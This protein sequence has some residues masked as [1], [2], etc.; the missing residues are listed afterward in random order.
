MTR[1][2]RGIEK[3]RKADAVVGVCDAAGLPMP[4]AP[5]WVEQESHA[6]V[7][8]CAVPELG[9]LCESD[10]AR[11]RARLAEVFNHLEPAGR[12]ADAARIEAPDGVHLGALRLLLDRHAAGPPALVHVRGRTIG[13]ADRDERNAAQRVVDL[14]SLCFS[15][16][17]VRGVFWNG[18]RDGDDGAGSGLLRA[19]LSAKPVFRLLQKLIGVVWHTRA[20]GVT[21]ADG[22]FHVRGFYGNY[23]IGVPVGER[24]T[25]ALFSL[26]PDAEEGMFR[27]VVSGERPA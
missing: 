27:V 12:P 9:G 13:M 1:T 25:V 2:L 26:R 10:Q 20:N 6:F 5:V 3:H 14:Y 24:A 18:L 23:R 17:A 4:G 22:L 11:Y 19:D 8:G 15:H 21:D 16:A 7:F